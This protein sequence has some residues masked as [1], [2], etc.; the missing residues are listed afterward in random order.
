M[1]GKVKPNLGRHQ[2]PPEWDEIITY[3]RG[4]D[5]QNYFLKIVENKIKTV[6]KPQYVDNIPKAVNGRIGDII[7]KRDPENTC[8]ELVQTL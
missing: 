8:E 1:S 3:F 6:T 7:K 2:K 4:S 5:L